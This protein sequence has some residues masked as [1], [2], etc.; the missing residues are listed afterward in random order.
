MYVYCG[1]NITRIM[2]YIML[3]VII[4]MR[5]I[6]IAVKLDVNTDK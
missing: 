5:H 1:E 6:N 3:P 2:Q 4:P